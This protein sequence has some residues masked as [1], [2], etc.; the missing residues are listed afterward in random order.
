MRTEEEIRL[1]FDELVEQRDSCT[2]G[3]SA[4]RI[5]N[6]RLQ[7]LAWVIK[8]PDMPDIAFTQATLNL[9]DCVG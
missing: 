6:H 4:R 2:E 7:G 3:S 8:H 1:K 9:L 5:L